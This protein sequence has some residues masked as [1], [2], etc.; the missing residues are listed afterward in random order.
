MEGP[1]GPK[2]ESPTKAVKGED[3][4]KDTNI[5]EVDEDKNSEQGG[6][7]SGSGR[8]RKADLRKEKTT[9]L[10]IP[11]VKTLLRN[12]QDLRELQSCCVFRHWAMNLHKI[13]A[14]ENSCFQ[15]CI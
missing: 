5:F 11:A 9:K 2:A 13:D 6:K 7:G 4:D 10:L 12:T 1:Q 3:K 14:L 8:T 15:R